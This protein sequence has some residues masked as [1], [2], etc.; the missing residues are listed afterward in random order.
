MLLDLTQQSQ[1]KTRSRVSPTSRD[2]AKYHHKRRET[3]V[4]IKVMDSI[5]KP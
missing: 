3:K 4:T 5:T 2:L 1:L